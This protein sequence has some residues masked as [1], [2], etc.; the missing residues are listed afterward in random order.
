MHGIRYVPSER[1][2]SDLYRELLPLV[3][4]AQVE[5]LDVPRLA[6]Q[7]TALERRVARGGKDSIGHGPGGR[8]D[9]ANAAA[10]ALVLTSAA[11][12]RPVAA[13]AWGG[14]EPGPPPGWR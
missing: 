11:T 2:K 3:N 14:A 5:L 12:K 9:L 1:V 8:D 10:G 7:L 4:A 13:I 6:T